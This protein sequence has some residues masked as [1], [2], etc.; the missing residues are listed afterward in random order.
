MFNY[1]NIDSAQFE[2]LALLYLQSRY[3]GS[4]WEP[5]KRSWDGNKDIQS[6]YTFFDQTMEY[7]AEAKFTPNPSKRNLQ[8]SQLDPTLVS[9]FLNKNPVT[10]N[11]ISN[12]NISENYI[13]RLTD[14][15]LKTNIGITLVL[16]EEFEQWLLKHPDICEAYQI[17]KNIITYEENIPKKCIIKQSLITEE[18]VDNTQYTFTKYLS[19]R[20]A[21]FLYLNIYSTESYNDCNLT[22]DIF[23]FINRSSIL[24]SAKEF[25]INKGWNGYKFEFIA[26]KI[27]EG[28][29]ELSIKQNSKELAKYQIPDIKI[30][31]DRSLIISYAQQEKALIDIS[32][33]IQESGKE[34]NFVKIN[35]VGASGKSHLLKQLH[36]D[37]ESR[38]DIFHVQF[39]YNN[40][41][42]AECLCRLLIYLNLGKIWKFDLELVSTELNNNINPVQY[43]LY[44][45][46]ISGLQG[47]A[48][49]VIE[50]VYNQINHLE[51]NLLFPTNV[52]IR[53]VAIL[54]DLHKL[55]NKQ[56]S[57]VERILY[58]YR[59]YNSSQTLILAS[60]GHVL[61]NTYDYSG[62]QRPYKAPEHV[63]AKKDKKYYYYIRY[64]TSSVRANVEQERELINM[65]N[66]APFDTRPYFEATESDISVALLT[67]HF[68]STRSKLAR[69]IG[70][71]GV[72]EVLGDMQLLVGP[73]EQQCISNV[74]L[75]MFCDHLDKFFPYTQVEIT[76]FPEGSINNPN[77][78]IEVPVIKGSV[79]TMIKRIMEKLQDMVIEEKVTKVDYQMES[80]RR[81]SYS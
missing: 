41:F 51:F 67:D 55:T 19:Y 38:Y 62:V 34:N 28:C 79:P 56:L 47:K 58:Q 50:Y 45:N 69:Q 44:E 36:Q 15:K 7:W 75:M 2:K 32:N 17:K 77:N 5:T 52:T 65:T 10:I 4:T 43:L 42:N 66:Y 16:K 22:S 29:V 80:I 40:T 74:A 73:L 71:R 37:L 31:E 68:N 46:L 59:Q 18:D 27:F 25:D 9:A 24:S 48:E 26:D 23:N 11:F 12:N 20:T 49:E 57:I 39:D 21:Y 30:L 63:T 13:F 3:P 81:F 61:N 70:K 14:F 1:T 64:T 33:Y 8:K 60:R 35:G 76:K 78:F 53:K 54:D 6:K 72:M